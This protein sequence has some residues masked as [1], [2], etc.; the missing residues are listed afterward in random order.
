[1]SG[2][3]GWRVPYSN[4]YCAD[5]PLRRE[6]LVV[7]EG[8]SLILQLFEDI[9]RGFHGSRHISLLDPL[10]YDPRSHSP[11][12]L[13]AFRR[14]EWGWLIHAGRPIA[15]PDKPHG[16]WELITVQANYKTLKIILVL[17]RGNDRTEYTPNPDEP[18]QDPQALRV[19]FYHHLCSR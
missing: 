1:M 18:P 9:Y 5:S 13:E 6:K 2:S 4:S 19:R 11:S 10:L 12:D 3:W 15:F 17:S 14:K 7:P 8:T 16:D